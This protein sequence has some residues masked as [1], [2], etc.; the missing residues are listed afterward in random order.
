MNEKEEKEEVKDRVKEKYLL[1]NPNEDEEEEVKDQVKKKHVLND[2]AEEEEVKDVVKEKHVLNDED[3]DEE[4]EVK[5]QVKEKHVLNDAN[6]E[7]EVTHQ[8]QDNLQTNYDKELRKLEKED[9]KVKFD[10]A[11][12]SAWIDLQHKAMLSDKEIEE[13]LNGLDD[14]KAIKRKVEALIKKSDEY[15]EEE[16][17][18]TGVTTVKSTKKI[19]PQLQHGKKE[20]TKRKKKK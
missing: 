9:A 12:A 1:N 14:V 16:T 18:E 13:E 2:E 15:F 4:E 6:E 17:N 10:Y 11:V 7:V 19:D 8:E 20:T 5:D 3:Q